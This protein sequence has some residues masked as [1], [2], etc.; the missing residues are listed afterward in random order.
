M[1]E[2]LKKVSEENDMFD[3]NQFFI[4]KEI[5]LTRWEIEYHG[6][7]H[8]IDSEVVIEA[9]LASRGNERRK[10]SGTI[11]SL[12][13]R[14]ASIVDYLKFLAECMVQNYLIGDSI[15]NT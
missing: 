4:E 3:L 9:I 15:E 7:T 13:F 10:I 6:E 11:F 12:N 5:P 8:F 1:K 2:I 14:N